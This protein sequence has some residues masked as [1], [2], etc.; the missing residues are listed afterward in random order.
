[1]GGNLLRGE[2]VGPEFRVVYTAEYSTTQDSV[3]YGVLQSVTIQHGANG[4]TNDLEELLEVEALAN[5]L[6]DQPFS[7]RVRADGN[8][9]ILK[10]VK[11]AG[12]DLHDE[13]DMAMIMRTVVVGSYTKQPAAPAPS[14]SLVPYPVYAAPVPQPNR[15]GL[16]QPAPQALVPGAVPQYPYPYGLPQPAPQ[17]LVPGAVPQY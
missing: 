5:S 11:F 10:D 9:L 6:I 16:P 2:L 1:V 3:M 4:Q 8:Q 14:V 12:L 17:A 13:D 7:A 15:Y